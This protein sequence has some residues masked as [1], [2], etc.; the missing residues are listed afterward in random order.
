MSSCTSFVPLNMPPDWRSCCLFLSM[1]TGTRQRWHRWEEGT[2]D[3]FR[4]K[5][6][7]ILPY[8]FFEDII[9]IS[10]LSQIQTTHLSQP[11]LHQKNPLRCHHTTSFSFRL[12]CYFL[13]PKKKEKTFIHS[14]YCSWE[15]QKSFVDIAQDDPSPAEGVRGPLSDAVAVV[16]HSI[17]HVVT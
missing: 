1:S 9:K 13:L 16:P 12:H 6:S 3:C 10:T 17:V 8:Y 2:N 4:L 11:V 15:R 7:H 5:S 14:L